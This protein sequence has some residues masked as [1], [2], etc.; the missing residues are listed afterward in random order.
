MQWH[1]ELDGASDCKAACEPGT[2]CQG[3]GVTWDTDICFS[4][5]DI[6]KAGDP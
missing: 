1:Q 3:W 4:S 6:I 2:A 5:Y